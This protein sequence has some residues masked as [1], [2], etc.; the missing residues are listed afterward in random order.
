MRL[1]N[2]LINEGWAQEVPSGTING[3]NK[4]F[5]LANTP[6]DPLSLELFLDGLKQRPTTDYTISGSTITFVNA[7]A[8]AQDIYAY[9]QKR[10]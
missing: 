8:L 2:R 9:Y 3:S 10:V 4:V 6:D 1:P 7:P 5:T